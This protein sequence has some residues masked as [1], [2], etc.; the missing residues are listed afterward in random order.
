[1][2]VHKLTVYVLDFDGLGSDGV[3]E[4]LENQRYP[5]HCISPNVLSVET[6]EIGE[7][8]DGNP[9]NFSDKAPA[10]YERIFAK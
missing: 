8:E 3:K 2:K 9:L 10:E 6:R 7:W 1:M 4:T 5:N